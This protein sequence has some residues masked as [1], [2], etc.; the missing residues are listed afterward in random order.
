[1]KVDQELEEAYQRDPNQTVEVIIMAKTPTEALR[2]TLE[3]HG[4][5]ITS[6]EHAGMGML[7]GRLRLQ[8]LPELRRLKEIESITLDAPQKAL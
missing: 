4:V 3:E 5:E 8:H 7:Y 6:R 2:Q 1:M